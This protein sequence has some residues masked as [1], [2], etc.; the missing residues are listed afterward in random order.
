MMA[1]IASR[2]SAECRARSCGPH[3]EYPASAPP[4]G[5]ALQR[6]P[7]Y[8][9]NQPFGCPPFDL[10]LLLARGGVVDERVARVDLHEVVHEQHL[11][12]A[13]DVDRNTGVRREHDRHEREMPRVLTAVL[14]A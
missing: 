9:A 11:H 2:S 7:G 10:L 3:Q 1:I 6:T 4:L 8:C 13:S 12:D 5:T 14:A